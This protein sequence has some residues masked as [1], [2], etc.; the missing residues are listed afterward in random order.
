MFDVYRQNQRRVNALDNFRQLSAII[1]N[2]ITGNY[3]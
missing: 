2:S 3:R 1:G